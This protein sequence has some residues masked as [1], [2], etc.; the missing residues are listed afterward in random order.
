MIDFIS[1]PFVLQLL[2]DRDVFTKMREF[3]AVLRVGGMLL[4]KELILED[5]DDEA[6]INK[7]T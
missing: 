1:A 6:F 3:A 7:D 2:N 5:D 4:I